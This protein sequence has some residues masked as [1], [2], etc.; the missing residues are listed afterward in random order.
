[1]GAAEAA[2]LATCGRTVV[3]VARRPR[4]VILP[5]GDELV[6]PDREPGPS[7]IRESNGRTL[8]AMVTAAGATPDLRGIVPDRLG[9][10]R[11]AI[12]AALRE[13]DV[14]LLSGGVSMGEYDLVGEALRAEG[15]RPEF[16]RV[17]I[18]PGKPL[19][20]GTGPGGGRG[21]GASL[22]FGLPGN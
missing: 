3:R 16:T 5:T 21:A 15:C 13:A 20:F 22:V 10:L 18:Q 12:A 9:A 17:A 1:V 4:V 8:R 11:Q 6:P 2:L 14:V 19:F 7:Q